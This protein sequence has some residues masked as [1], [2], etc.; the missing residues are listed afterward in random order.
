MVRGGQNG[1]EIDAAVGIEFPPDAFPIGVDR[2][3]ADAGVPIAGG[4]FVP[5]EA[6]DAGFEAA[7]PAGQQG[8]EIFVHH[9]A[10]AAH[11][12]G[13]GTEKVVAERSG[14]EGARGYLT[15]GG[16]EGAAGSG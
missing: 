4:I 11:Q 5:I 2:H 16:R 12:Q 15:G 9:V 3:L 13:F 8:L 1:Q 10:P 14:G 7:E 6:R